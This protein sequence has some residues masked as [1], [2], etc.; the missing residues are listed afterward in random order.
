MVHLNSGM[1][2]END[3]AE[4]LVIQFTNNGLIVF[5]TGDTTKKDEVCPAQ[6]FNFSSETVKTAGNTTVLKTQ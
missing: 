4:T 1:M 2:N 5:F 3:T 6:L